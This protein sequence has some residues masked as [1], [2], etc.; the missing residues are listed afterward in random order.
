M[1]NPTVYV[2]NSH[3][4]CSASC[5]KSRF[6]GEEPPPAEVRKAGLPMQVDNPAVD[7]ALKRLECDNCGLNLRDLVMTRAQEP[8]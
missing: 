5:M 4:F 2:W 8:R 1:R 7:A 3:V 6:V